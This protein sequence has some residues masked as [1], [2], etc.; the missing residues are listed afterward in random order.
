MTIASL[1]TCCSNSEVWSGE[2]MVFI[3]T[4]PF[5]FHFLYK[6]VWVTRWVPLRMAPG[7]LLRYTCKSTAQ[8]NPSISHLGVFTYLLEFQKLT[9]ASGLEGG[10][11]YSYF[12]FFN[13]FIV[14][15]RIIALQN[16]VVF[17]QTSTWNSHR[18]TCIPSFLKLPP[19]SLPT[20]PLQVDTEPLFE[21]PEPDSKFPLAIYLTYGNVGF[22]VTLPIH[23]TLSPCP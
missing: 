12:F 7:N 11:L 3:I 14:N 18:Y 6:L 10:H 13:L 23:L 19:I 22:H 5:S 17:C 4:G 9:D 21:F 8:Q 20:S 1:D 15:W 2:L 16:F